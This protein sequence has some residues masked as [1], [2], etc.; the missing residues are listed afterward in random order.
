MAVY[1]MDVELLFSAQPFGQ[2]PLMSSGQ[3]ET[4]QTTGSLCIACHV[5]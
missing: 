2:V 3:A 5:L 1:E 4:S